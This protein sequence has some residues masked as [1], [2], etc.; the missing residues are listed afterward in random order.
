MLRIRREVDKK[1]EEITGLVQVHLDL[2]CHFV[3]NCLQFDCCLITNEKINRL[4]Y[5]LSQRE[6]DQETSSSV[7]VVKENSNQNQLSL[8]GKKTL[9]KPTGKENLPEKKLT[10]KENLSVK[11]DVKR[12][13][14]TN[15]TI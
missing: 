2:V 7:E 4:K 11:K 15:L 12:N 14:V 6:I 3:V 9:K 1:I 13:K 10:S 8:L 5:C